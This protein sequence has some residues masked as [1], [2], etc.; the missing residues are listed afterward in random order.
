M[1]Q[2]GLKQSHVIEENPWKIYIVCTY[3]IYLNINCTTTLF[4][5]F[6]TERDFIIEKQKVQHFVQYSKYLSNPPSLATQ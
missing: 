4:S 5:L 3:Y 1:I 2:F 6:L